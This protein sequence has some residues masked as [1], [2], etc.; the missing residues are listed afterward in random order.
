M[1]RYLKLSLFLI[2]FI[3]SVLACM[4]YINGLNPNEFESKSFSNPN[5]S[6]NGKVNGISAINYTASPK[7]NIWTNASS[8]T[9]YLPCAAFASGLESKVTAINGNKITIHIQS[10]DRKIFGKA[11]TAYVKTMDLLA[12]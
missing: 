12:M 6:K 3:L 8:G 2:S 7:V 9:L 10:G 1:R 5:T 11:G 4:V